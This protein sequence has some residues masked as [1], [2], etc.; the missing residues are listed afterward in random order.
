MVDAVARQQ[1]AAPD[2][3]LARSL[4]AAQLDLGDPGLQIIDQ[5]LGSPD[6]VEEARG[7]GIE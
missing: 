1:L 4:A 3:T 2:M 5:P 7:A 6:I